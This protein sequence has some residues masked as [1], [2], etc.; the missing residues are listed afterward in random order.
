MSALCHGPVVDDQLAEIESGKVIRFDSAKCIYM[1]TQIIISNQ[2]QIKVGRNANG[3]AG[4]EHGCLPVKIVADG[5][6]EP[7]FLQNVNIY[8]AYR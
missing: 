6:C 7:V 2:D 3:A 1:I 5:R 8:V 4:T